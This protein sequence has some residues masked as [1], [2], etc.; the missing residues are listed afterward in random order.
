MHRA[1]SNSK[2]KFSENIVVLLLEKQ[3]LI[4][5][6]DSNG[7]TPLHIACSENNRKVAEKLI[8]Q[9]AEVSQIFFFYSLNFLIYLLLNKGFR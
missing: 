8:L 2:S 3:A 7:D 6:Q 1:A 5:I 4:N 9:G